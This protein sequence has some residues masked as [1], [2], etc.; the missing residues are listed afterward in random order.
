MSKRSEKNYI[1][2]KNTAI[3]DLHQYVRSI[4]WPIEDISISPSMSKGSK[5]GKPISISMKEY[6]WNTIDRHTK[7]IRIAKATWIKYAIFKLLQ[8][9][10]VYCFKNRKIKKNE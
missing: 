9:E 8:E 7:A 6:E 4:K 2:E 3:E 10:Q 5:L 1:E